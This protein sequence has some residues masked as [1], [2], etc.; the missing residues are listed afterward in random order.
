MSETLSN[1]AHEDRRFDP[2]ADFAA[3]ANLK[4]DAYEEADADRL[5]FWAKQ[6]ERISWAEPFTEVLDWSN[7][8]FA[9]WYVGGRLNASYNCL[10]RHI[11]AGKGDKVAFYF[12]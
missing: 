3:Q 10:D 7:A 9:K 6:A 5:A 4:A 12:E 1:R 2:P 8:P 11:E